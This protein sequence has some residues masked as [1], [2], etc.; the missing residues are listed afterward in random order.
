M[1]TADRSNNHPSSI[2]SEM[3][4]RPHFAPPEL[5]LVRTASYKHDAPERGDRSFH[6]GLLV[7]VYDTQRLQFSSSQRKK[8]A[9]IRKTALSLFEYPSQKLVA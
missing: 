4:V 9:I 5:E 6:L 8:A 7:S 3:S 1:F 2:R